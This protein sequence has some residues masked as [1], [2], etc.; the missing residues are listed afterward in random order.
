MVALGKDGNAAAAGADH[1]GPCIVQI[2]DAGPLHDVNRLGGGNIPPPA[3]AG[4]L[5][6]QVTGLLRHLAGLLLGEEF[7]DGL[8]GVEKGG[9]IP[10][11]DG[12]GDDIADGLVHAAVEKLLPQGDIQVIADI[13]LTHSAA[14]GQRR[15][16]LRVVFVGESGHGIVDDADLRA[17]AV[18]HHDLV[19]LLDEIDDG[20]GGGFY[21]AG[22]LGQG[23]AQRVAAQCDDDFA[24]FNLPL[25]F[26]F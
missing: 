22:L 2:F 21:G 25:P 14:D 23:G 18:G 26:S 4:I 15:E 11:N 7:A 6:H 13:G 9:V 24:H 12:L 8:G 1:H 19:A 5:F 20:A 16:A 3:A 17:V 10:G